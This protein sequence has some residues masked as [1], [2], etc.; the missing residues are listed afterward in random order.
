[1]SCSGWKSVAKTGRKCCSLEGS[2]AA[3][4]ELLWPE[5][6]CYYSREVEAVLRQKNCCFC[7]NLV[8]EADKEEL[9]LEMNAVAWKD[10]G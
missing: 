5:M 10:V 9:Q 2:A 1:M 6:S 4:N 3:E 8:A 7:R